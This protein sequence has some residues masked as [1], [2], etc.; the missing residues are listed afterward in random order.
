MLV[1]R[2]AAAA[3][4]SAAA[5]PL[6]FGAPLPAQPAGQTI[7]VWSYGFSPRP[8]RLA[9]GRRVTLT[10]V[11]RSGKGHDFT[12]KGFF[13]NATIL[14]GAAPGGAIGLRPNETKSITLIPRPGTYRAHCTHF[15]HTQL[16]MTD[17]IIVT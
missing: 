8:I 16:G 14:A 13:G 6:A 3:A 11:N 5:L 1:S 7:L 10:F 15:F 12:A 17:T 2:L 9:A 4:L